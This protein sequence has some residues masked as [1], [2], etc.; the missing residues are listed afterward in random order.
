M[1]IKLAN[2]STNNTT[3][4]KQV[5]VCDFYDKQWG[6]ILRP[7]QDIA[8]GIAFFASKL[9][10]NNNVLYSQEKR[11]TL[12]NLLKKNSYNLSSINEKVYC[13]C[14]SFVGTC[15]NA[16]GIHFELFDFTTR[17]MRDVLSKNGFV[18]IMFRDEKQLL[19]GDILLKEGS[20]SVIVVSVSE[21]E[22]V[23]KDGRVYINDINSYLNVREKASINS[24]VV[25]RLYFGDRVKVLS[26]E[27][28]FYYIETDSIKGY[29]YK[30]YIR[31]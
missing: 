21:I 23:E 16:Q 1:K 5:R 22:L 4:E 6:W 15:I 31:I 29:C 20:H 17:T 19:K 2:A 14:S 12:N 7:S 8:N 10:E 30:A 9:C 3:E 13:D 11:L 27:G 18:A 26:Q 24:K 25:A 28:D